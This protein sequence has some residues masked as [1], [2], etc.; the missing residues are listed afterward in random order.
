MNQINMVSGRCQ[1][2]K[3]SM[4]RFDVRQRSISAAKILACFSLLLVLSTSQLTA[5]DL[6]GKWRGTI[7]AP[8]NTLDLLLV[9]KVSG[10]DVTG[11]AGPNEERRLPIENGQFKGNKLTFQV[12]MPTGATLRFELTL[13]GDSLKGSGVRSFNGE[14]DSA[15]ID[16][17]RVAS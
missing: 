9:L 1:Y 6:N 5:A 3:V 13:D 17:K 8:D 10:S 11:S 12:T 2:G 7:S 14:S 15:T 4:P 16:L